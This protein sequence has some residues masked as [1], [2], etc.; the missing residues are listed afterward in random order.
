MCAAVQD[1]LTAV[2]LSESVYKMV[3]ESPQTVVNHVND[4]MSTFPAHARVRLTVQCSLAGVP[5]RYLVAEGDDAL[6]VAFVGT[7]RLQDLLIDL[8]YWQ[9]PVLLS[10]E[11]PDSGLLV[12]QGFMSRARRIPVE[13]LFRRARERN[14]HLV[15]CGALPRSRACEKCAYRR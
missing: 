7:K 3:D 11:L 6:Y 4:I 2:A 5:H 1:I 13:Q 12:H 15:F 9:Q 14:K 10:E 8:N